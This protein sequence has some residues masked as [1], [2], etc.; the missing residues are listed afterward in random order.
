MVTG[1]SQNAYTSYLPFSSPQI[2]RI[3]PFLETWRLLAHLQDSFRQV[4]IIL[5][6]NLGL[7]TAS[8]KFWGVIVGVHNV[9]K[10]LHGARFFPERCLDHEYMLKNEN[11]RGMVNAGRAIQCLLMAQICKILPKELKF[12]I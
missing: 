5:F 3:Y 1:P 12:L 10:N 8:T 9:Y 7:V 4:T 2:T 6:G 11:L